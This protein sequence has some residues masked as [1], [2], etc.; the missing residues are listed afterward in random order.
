MY[1]IAI[2]DDDSIFSDYL[3]ENIKKIM[4]ENGLVQGTDYDIEQFNEA[5]GLQH[6]IRRNPN[7][8]Q[9]L[10]LDIELPGE[11]GMDIARTFREQQVTSSIIFITVHRD[12]IYE[13]FDTQPLWYLLKPLDYEK[14]RK[15]LLDDYRRNYAKA[16][17]AVKIEG[18][19]MA[20]PFHEI[21]ALESTQHRTRIWLSEKFYDWNGALSALKPQLPAFCFCQSHNSYMINLSHVKEILRADV[22]MDN[23]RSFPVSR[24]YHD[25]TLEKYFN[26]LRL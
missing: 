15:I 24:R 25:Q 9:L 2:C 3:H 10:L 26:Y 5:A 19:Q 12:Y 23:N 16:R 7:G 14:F 4:N 11:N 13:C 1:R 21:Y 20:I 6:M 22:L 8:Y 18:R 17:L